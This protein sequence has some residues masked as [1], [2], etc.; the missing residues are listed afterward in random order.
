MEL[1]EGPFRRIEESNPTRFSLSFFLW[2][3]HRCWYR[4]TWKTYTT[5]TNGGRVSSPFWRRGLFGDGWEINFVPGM[6]RSEI[7]SASV[8]KKIALRFQ[9]GGA[10]KLGFCELTFPDRLAMC[11]HLMNM[12][13]TISFFK[14]IFSRQN[15]YTLSC[16]GLI[17]LML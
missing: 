8:R 10:I 17:L 15:C 1:S 12:G 16:H 7:Y 6:F 3:H 2:F 4:F 14:L 11:M 9:E 13:S 5:F